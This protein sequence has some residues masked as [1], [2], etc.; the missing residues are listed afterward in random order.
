M[1]IINENEGCYVPLF[2]G[3]LDRIT[4]TTQSDS[5]SQSSGQYLM[6]DIWFDYFNPNSGC[7]EPVIEQ[8]PLMYKVTQTGKS[9]DTKMQLVEA[10]CMNVT[11][12]LATN[13]AVVNRLWAQSTETAAKFKK[14][15]EE[16]KTFGTTARETQLAKKQLTK[17]RSLTTKKTH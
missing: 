12:D 7:Y 6:L 14:R 15:S 9:S 17:S 13:I 10:I 4:Y 2:F 3:V 5:E 1:I 16:F 11:V 8:F